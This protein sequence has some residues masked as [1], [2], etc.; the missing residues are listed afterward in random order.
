MCKIKADAML[1]QFRKV[2]EEGGNKYKHAKERVL[3]PGRKLR[4]VL[5]KF[6]ADA[7]IFKDHGCAI[8]GAVA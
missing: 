3:E 6:N 4:L 7:A 5:V 8:L 2:N 1:N